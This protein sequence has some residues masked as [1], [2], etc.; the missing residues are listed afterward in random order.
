MQN[1]AN[2]QDDVTVEQGLHPLDQ[3]ENDKEVLQSDIQNQSVKA[4][5]QSEKKKVYTS[6]AEKIKDEVEAEYKAAKGKE[7]EDVMRNQMTPIVQYVSGKCEEDPDYNAL[8]IQD[9]KTWKRC[10]QF[11]M[12]KAQEMAAK[13]STGLLVEGNTILKW[14]DEYYKL[15]DKKQAEKEA[16]GSQKRKVNDK[17]SA[18]NKNTAKNDSKAKI[19]SNKVASEATQHAPSNPGKKKKEIEGQFSLFDFM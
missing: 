6:G 4:N 7:V 9:H 3:S 14:I 12:K 8:V 1:N 16:A 17:K 13:G 19:Q 18:K 10:Y 2:L 11:M 15:D 5:K